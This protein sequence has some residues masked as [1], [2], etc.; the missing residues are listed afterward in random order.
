MNIPFDAPLQS[1]KS[2]HHYLQSLIEKRLWLKVIIAMVLG[3]VVGFALSSQAGL[4]P[5]SFTLPLI[6]WLGL[7]GMLFLKLVQMIMIPLIFAS[8]IQG[9]TANESLEQLKK[10][11]LNVTLY[12]IA[13]TAIAV[14]IGTSIAYLISPGKYFD[15]GALG[16]ADTVPE[17]ATA[18]GVQTLPT[19]KDVPAY[20]SNLLPDNPL[21]SMVSG[22]MLNIV[23]FAI[24][25]GIALISMSRATAQ[26]LL[27]I[28]N[29][30]L[31]VCMTIVKW[32]MRIVPYAVFGLMAQLCASIGLSSILGIGAYILSVI[33]GLVLLL[34]V[35]L[36]IVGV[37]AGK[38][39]V[40]F[41]KSIK[42]AQLLAFSTT[43]SAAVMPLSMK[44]AEEKLKVRPAISN[45]I[46]PIGATINMD[47]T[48]L[49]QCVSAVFIAQVYGIELSLLNLLFMMITVITASIGT[50]S[51][52]GGGII[53]LGS[54]LQSVGIPAE[55]IVLIIGV[56]RILGMFR[57]TLNVTGDLTA[58]I[59]FDKWLGIDKPPAAVEEATQ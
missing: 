39:P 43:S 21:A 52:P 38:S 22:E 14:T 9:I 27:A 26:P 37:L 10:M 41:L 36:L 46:I 58:C 5:E 59:L 35:Y 19:F 24:I 47:G 54:V 23:L 56:E 33:I 20:I 8:I 17:T 51:I 32:A 53:I 1:I 34:I 50:P 11:G 49:Y 42:N 6:S 16:G 28:L 18:G 13:S 7:P 30:T 4:L 40:W 25:V 2:L 55:G 12:F 44:I 48:A 15:A 45:F 57:A 29:A 31:E 3:I